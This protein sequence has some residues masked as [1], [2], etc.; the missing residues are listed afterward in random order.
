MEIYH[1][2][3]GAYICYK[4]VTC[5]MHIYSTYLGMEGR[6]YSSAGLCWFLLRCHLNPWCSCA[7]S[8]GRMQWHHHSLDERTEELTIYLKTVE[9]ENACLGWL[10][11]HHLLITLS[12]TNTMAIKTSND[13]ISPS[14]C[15]WNMMSVVVSKGAN[16]HLIELNI[17]IIVIV[18]ILACLILLFSSLIRWWIKTIALF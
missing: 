8:F 5:N 11:W 18:N 4:P 13:E 7:R 2:L 15:K 1:W 16:G 17:F 6:A 3:S 14:S 10:V 12:I 9:S